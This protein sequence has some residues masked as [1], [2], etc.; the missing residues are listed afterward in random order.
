MAPTCLHEYV[1]FHNPLF[2]SS[3]HPC[4][5]RGF[6]NVGRAANASRSRIEQMDAYRGAFKEEYL[7]LH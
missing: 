2:H 7:I 1:H 4:I 6:E 3:A 5:I